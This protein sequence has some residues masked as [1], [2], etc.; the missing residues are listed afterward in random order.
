MYI[1]SSPT[2]S[3]SLPPI[4]MSYTFFCNE[5]QLLFHTGMLTDLVHLIW[6]NVECQVI[7]VLTF[8][9]ILANHIEHVFMSL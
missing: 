6:Y 4:L 5:L 3:S 1:I 9:S 8:I 2:L 7:A